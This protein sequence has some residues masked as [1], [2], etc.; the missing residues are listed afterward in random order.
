MSERSNNRRGGGVKVSAKPPRLYW[1]WARSV[2]F[3]HRARLALR[4]FFRPLPGCSR[5]LDW[6]KV[7]HHCD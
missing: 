7:H 2:L 6:K 5:S 1:L 3:F 4:A